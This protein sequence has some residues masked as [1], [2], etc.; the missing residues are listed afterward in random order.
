[1]ADFENFSPDTLNYDTVSVNEGIWL[2]ELQQTVTAY[3]I[4]LLQDLLPIYS[5]FLSN[6]T[7]QTV[8]CRTTQ[9]L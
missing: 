1:M 2:S 3:T 8:Y 9:N 4:Q 5:W 7:R 6:T